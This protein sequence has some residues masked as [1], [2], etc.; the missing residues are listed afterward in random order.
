MR[1]LVFFGLVGIHFSISKNFVS[2]KKALFYV[3][4]QS[5]TFNKARPVPFT[6]IY[7]FSIYVYI[8]FKITL[9]LLLCCVNK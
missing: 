8:R 1:I 9:K 5:F 3:F 7:T 2:Y 6:L 4:G